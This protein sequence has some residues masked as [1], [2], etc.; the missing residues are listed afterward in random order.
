MAADRSVWTRPIMIILGFGS[1]VGDRDFAIHGLDYPRRVVT[2]TGESF[3]VRHPQRFYPPNPKVG[4]PPSIAELFLFPYGS[5]P[6][7]L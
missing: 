4:S 5:Y 7:E 3:N 6:L 1:R 2:T